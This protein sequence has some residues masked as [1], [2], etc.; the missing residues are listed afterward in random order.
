EIWQTA[1]RRH[2]SG[3]DTV[4]VASYLQART[5]TLS[6][7]RE[8]PPGIEGA[9]EGRRASAPLLRSGWERRIDRE[10]YAFPVRRTEGRGSYLSWSYPPLEADFAPHFGSEAFGERHDFRFQF[11][12]DDG[13]TVHFC[14]RDD[15][16]PFMEGVIEI[17]PDSLIQRVEWRFHTPDPVEEAG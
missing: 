7:S 5:D 17:G 16:D 6:G 8:G 14:A 1:A 15:D 4:G 13:W 3:L 12:S 11:E 9:A 2:R 10:G